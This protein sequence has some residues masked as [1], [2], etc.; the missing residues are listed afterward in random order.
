VQAR[1]GRD[2][3]EL[4]HFLTKETMMVLGVTCAS[5]LAAG[6][7]APVLPLYLNDLGIEAEMLGLM[8]SLSAVA[9]AAGEFTSGLLVDRIGVK[10]A[11]LAAT[12]LYA[13]SISGFLFAENVPTIL[14]FFILYGLLQGPVFVIGRWHMAINSQPNARVFGIALLMMVLSGSY[15]IG[16]FGSGWIA[17]SWG[18][19]ASILSAIVPPIVIGLI[20]VASMHKL[21]F[22]IPLP[23]KD[24]RHAISGITPA[25]RG[26]ITK[27]ILCIGGLAALQFASFGILR[28]FLPLFTTETMG[29]GVAN[30]GILFGIHGLMQIFA[31]IPLATLAD[32]QGKVRYILLGTTG[33]FLA[34]L[35]IAIANSFIWLLVLMACYSMAFTVFSNTA[36]AYLA[37]RVP[38]TRQGISMGAYGVMEGVGLIAGPAAA[39]WFWESFGPRSIFLLGSGLSAIGF[40]VFFTLMRE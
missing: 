23:S 39:G 5:F 4:R 13:A 15:S 21:R 2:I 9:S 29:M 31:A 36:T 17:A 37:E 14:L 18:N 40:M 3:R 26:S 27:R 12:L 10:A 11:I 35:G 33:I 22:G 32:R 30:V 6:L 7:L 16:S 1:L 20:L 25:A 24:S 38:N 34:T 19:R 8:F 28:T